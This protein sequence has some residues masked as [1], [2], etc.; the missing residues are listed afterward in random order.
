[1]T[2]S[3]NSGT[4]TAKPLVIAHRGEA[5]SRPENTLAAFEAALAAGADGIE[6]DSRLSA[7]GVPVVI[8]DP[9]LTRTAGVRGKV[10]SRTLEQL[11][12]LD[13]GEGESI[14]TLAETSD[15][16]RG[17]AL[18][19]LEFKEV[20]AVAPSIAALKGHHAGGLMFC[21]FLPKALRACKD[22]WPEVPTL[23][24]TG[25]RNPNPVAR[26]RESFPL[27][28]IKRV[29]ADGLSCHHSALSP[30]RA[31]QVRSAGLG[32]VTWCTVEEEEKPPRWFEKALEAAPDALV[33]T[34]PRKLLELLADSR[35]DYRGS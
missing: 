20:L 1:M 19:C 18:L 11:R 31:A 28:T 8:H 13:A 15:L 3:R 17:R 24:I 14:P 22:L 9:T 5:S 4:K 6:C 34:W 21:S 29:D 16:C 7:D 26:W 2:I 12:L 10:G 27:S 23:L 35:R 25:S 30:K 32:L 33:T